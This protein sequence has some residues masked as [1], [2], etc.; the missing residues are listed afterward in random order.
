MKKDIILIIGGGGMA[1]IFSSGVLRSFENDEIYDRVHSVYSVS[2]GACT[3][4][5][6]LAKESELGGKTFYT[7][8]N[9]DKF[10]KGHFIRYFFQV[11]KHKKNSSQKI[12][13]IFN[14]DYFTKIILHSKDKIDMDK[15]IKSKIPFYVKVFNNTKKIHQYLL[16]K[17]PYA[18]EKVIAS[19]SMTPLISKSIIINNEELFDGDTIPSN[20]E[21]EIIKKNQNK[22]IIKI[23]NSNNSLIDHFNI[24]ILFILY[25][26]LRRMYGSKVSN[27]YFTNFFRR[28][29]WEK[30]IKKYN[31]LISIKNSVPLSS[32]SKDE[33]K[34]KKTY[35]VGLKKGNEILAQIKKAPSKFYSHSLFPTKQLQL[36]GTIFLKS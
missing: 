18:Y 6:F 25:I 15:V 8:F 7:R 35:D 31:N 28:P 26:L 20:L 21:E 27:L 17:N 36:S 14:F 33:D 2:A 1:G 9:N 23:N 16:V 30:N 5:R 22:I 13:D 12:D 3:G 29:F 10:I 34:L 24:F 19:A 4:A 11:L 32:F